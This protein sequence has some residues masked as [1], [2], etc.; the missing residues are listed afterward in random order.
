MSYLN[1]IQ[2]SDLR[3][4]SETTISQINSLAS[5]SDF[6]PETVAE[7]AQAA[8][9]ICEW[10]KKCDQFLQKLLTFKPSLERLDKI[11]GESESKRLVLDVMQKELDAISSIVA[12]TV[13]KRS[14]LK[15]EFDGITGELSKTSEK[16][17]RINLLTGYLSTHM[18]IWESNIKNLEDRASVSDGNCILS[19]ACIEYLGQFDKDERDSL[20]NEWQ[21]T[22][23]TRGIKFTMNFELDKFLGFESEVY[24]WR[25]A[26]LP[27]SSLNL[28]NA[29]ILK[30]NKKTKLVYDPNDTCL[31]WLKQMSS[32]KQK[33]LQITSLND[34][35]LSHKLQL[36]LEKGQLLVIDFFDG[37]ISA[38]VNSLLNKV[39]RDTEGQKT[40][41]VEEMWYSF[42]DK[43]ELVLMTRDNKVISFPWVQA[44]CCLVQFCLDNTGLHETLKTMLGRIFDEESERQ[45][46][47]ALD[48]R[49]KKR[50]FVSESQDRILRRLILNSDEVVLEDSDYM[51]ML[52]KYAEFSSAIDSQAAVNKEDNEIVEKTA[53]D[54]LLHFLV[55]LYSMTDRFSVWSEGLKVSANSYVKLVE[56][57]VQR[58][59]LDSIGAID[60]D[61]TLLI[62]RDAFNLIAAG[63]NN[64][65]RLFMLIDLCVM[66]LKQYNQ[67][68]QDL[69]SYIIT[70]YS[71]NK[72]SLV[73]DMNLDL[74]N[75]VWQ[76]LQSL[77]SMVPGIELDHLPALVQVFK[78]V[79]IIGI[80]DAI[81][82]ALRKTISLTSLERLAMYVSFMPEN[83]NLCLE[84]FAE[85]VLPGSSKQ[86]NNSL[87]GMLDKVSYDQPVIFMSESTCDYSELTAAINLKFNIRAALMFSGNISWDQVKVAMD[88]ATLTGNVIILS[89]FN[90]NK[91]LHEPISR[92]MREINSRPRKP[93]LTFRLVLTM[94]P[95]LS[96]ISIELL[97]MSLKLFRSSTSA[98]AD[99][100]APYYKQLDVESF[101][102]CGIILQNIALNAI[103]AYY[104]MS[105]RSSYS[106][107]GF[108]DPV[109]LTDMD[110]KALVHV[111]NSMARQRLKVKSVD[112][113]FVGKQLY[114]ILFSDLSNIIDEA[115]VE[116]YWQQAFV[117]TNKQCLQL[118]GLE[119]GREWQ[120]RFPE[121]FRDVVAE[122]SA[123]PEVK[124][125]KLTG[126]SQQSI[127]ETQKLKGEFFSRNIINLEKKA[128]TEIFKSDVVINIL[129]TFDAGAMIN[130]LIA[131]LPNPILLRRLEEL[132]EECRYSYLKR[133]LLKEVILF[134]ELIM[135]VR[136]DLG[137]YMQIVT[138]KYRPDTRLAHDLHEL[139][140]D[141][142]PHIWMTLSGKIGIPLTTWMKRI[143]EREKFLE[144]IVGNN[145]LKA[146]LFDV[147]LITDVKALL[148]A[149]ELDCAYQR[150]PSMQFHDMITTFKLTQV[151]ERHVSSL[152]Q[153]D[154]YKSRMVYTCMDSSSFTDT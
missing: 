61:K 17:R 60:R 40:I 97:S 115:T 142:V 101:I 153:V 79:S 58:L 145:F 30:H 50:A 6:D 84:I 132:K 63:V 75:T 103:L 99:S 74:G 95:D 54:G 121:A 44:S 71:A 111:L 86:A 64:E 94:P 48:E 15:M 146:Y 134:N 26:G 122:V 20:K 3:Q 13:E 65:V 27:E 45:Q 57:C 73:D 98:K 7:S 150:A 119:I 12:D 55:E 10:C 5:Q 85:D 105:H 62:V 131:Q 34:S 108:F 22:L 21:K 68:R 52:Q 133:F 127:E 8:R 47:A 91:T 1:R 33:A 96:N 87:D 117:I 39:I 66:I 92:Y 113:S 148:Q 35:Q 46:L 100:I 37:Q 112:I 76:K 110:F 151:F 2:S 136:A 59:S 69:W 106:K 118:R 78:Q 18:S 152:V 116:W 67:F 102:P 129:K 125:D 81:N 114:S 93:K 23:S 130:G 43:F 56:K 104:A 149:Y 143:F 14:V 135:T 9:E 42:D 82:E 154:L 41:K 29:L 109:T 31:N 16:V 83:F 28:E 53:V 128:Y 107:D 4:L 141:R 123:S 138:D 32:T 126:I 120:I 77:R 124:G 38:V 88:K 36:S 147:R 72:S 90:L 80:E 70:P 89:E 11:K 144:K 24:S 25:I 140:V 51:A 49:L 137:S 19:A 139:S